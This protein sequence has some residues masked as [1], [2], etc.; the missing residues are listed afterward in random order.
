MALE[1]RARGNLRDRADQRGPM[2]AIVHAR[3]IALGLRQEELADLADCS[4]RFVHDLESGKQTLQLAKTVDVLG[5]LGLH[6]EIREG[7]S[8]GVGVEDGI[9][10]EYGLE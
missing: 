7:T 10:R 2:A 5:A 1:R 4:T 6:L 3:R 9:R 8:G